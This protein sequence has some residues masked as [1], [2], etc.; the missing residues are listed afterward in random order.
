MA[1]TPLIMPP[2]LTQLDL[3]PAR[4]K[5]PRVSDDDIATL[6]QH[7]RGRG[8]LTSAE[9]LADP[10]FADW[11]ERY[12]R[13]VASASNGRVLSY[14]GSPGYRITKESTIE[15]IQAADTLRHQADEMRER[16]LQIQR[17]YHGKL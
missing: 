9:I 8:W 4:A 7:L 6:Q 3:L 12:L 1:T 10:G 16:W 14:P 2:E 15:E 17:I 11:T 13:A 5:A